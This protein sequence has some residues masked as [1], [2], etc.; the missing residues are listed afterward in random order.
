M[1]SFVSRPHDPLAAARLADALGVSATLGQLLLHRGLQAPEAARAFLDA[2]LRDMTAPDDM[3]DREAAA[4]RLARAVRA[5]ERIVL[6]GDYD[7]DGTSSAALLADVLERLGGDVS[8]LAANRFEGGYGFSRAA[9]A[10]CL[11]AGARLIVTCDCGSSDHERIAEA[12]RAGVDV[13]VVDHHLVPEEPLP[14]LAFVNP[15]RPD[16]GHTYKHM[17]SAGLAFSL[18]AAVRRRLGKELDLRP[19]LDLVAVGT[20]ADVAPLDG[21]NRRMVRAGLRAMARGEARPGLGALMR[22]ARLPMGGALGAREVAWRIAPRLNA[23]GRLGSAQPTLDLLRAKTSAEAERLAL[24][25]ESANRERRRLG[26]RALRE[27]SA[28]LEAR[29]VPPVGRALVV[30]G[31]GWHRGVVGIVAGRLASRYGVPVA[32]IA[33]DGKAGHGSVRSAAGVDVHA[34]LA[35]C[36][37]MLLRWG[38]HAAA[39]GFT[40]HAAK[41]SVFREAFEEAAGKLAGTEPEGPLV[42]VVLDGEQFPVPSAAELD[43]LEPFGEGN[44]EPLFALRG[45]QVESARPVG[46][47]G[48]HLAMSLRLGAQ[49][50][51]AF[52][53][54]LGHRL[55]ALRAAQ[56]LLG[57]LQRDSWQ[58]GERLQLLI[59]E[60]TNPG[61]S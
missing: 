25:L 1:R 17:A 54:R 33:L 16:C 24:V 40:L 27:A 15:H 36:A 50:L 57:R 7:V 22:L 58:G 31:E 56:A 42:D 52:G 3:A 34:A 45:V 49:R 53:P 11:E 20:I 35:R 26:E 30:A 28:Q 55:E 12:A 29:G 9:L 48:R 6:F 59:E 21:D 2:R 14:A 19:W 8:A 47:E 43:R 46:A 10:R 51:R 5:G 60:G 18:A 4:D 44:P 23:P 41:L 13:V 32:C 39:A 37:P 38:G 61:A